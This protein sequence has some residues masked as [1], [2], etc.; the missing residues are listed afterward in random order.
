MLHVT[1]HSLRCGDRQRLGNRRQITNRIVNHRDVLLLMA[2]KLI[3][4][5]C[6]WGEI[7]QNGALGNLK[8][9]W[10]GPN[11]AEGLQNG[12]LIKQEA[13]FG[14]VDGTTRFC[15]FYDFLEI[16]VLDLFK[17]R[18][19]DSCLDEVQE[20]HQRFILV[21]RELQHLRSGLHCLTLIFTVFRSLATLYQLSLLTI[22]CQ[23]II[24]LEKSPINLLGKDFL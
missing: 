8:N 10:W 12:K 4:P 2:S 22:F 3:Q 7:D 14:Q 19:W 13:T 11:N 20:R 16:I 17:L 1:I 21:E 24:R 6:W 15:L 18:V 5:I 9:R 23:L